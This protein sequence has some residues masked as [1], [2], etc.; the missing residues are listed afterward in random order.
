[1]TKTE[2]AEILANDVRVRARRTGAAID[3]DLVEARLSEARHLGGLYPAAAATGVSW[4]T[5]LRAAT[6]SAL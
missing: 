2:A 3:K 5:V 6:R 1:M 4:R